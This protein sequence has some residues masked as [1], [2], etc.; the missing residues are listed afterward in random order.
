[1]TWQNMFQ[2]TTTLGEDPRSYWG[3]FFEGKTGLHPLS[4]WT[5]E[6]D[7][8]DGNRT[9]ANY[10][11]SPAG[12][13]ATA[14]LISP[15]VLQLQGTTAGAGN[16]DWFQAPSAIEIADVRTKRWMF[17]YRLSCAHAPAAASR[18]AAGFFASTG[19]IMVGL[20]YGGAVANWQYSRATNTVANTL[21]TGKAIDSSG[22]VFPWV[23]LF[24]D[25]TN[26]RYCIDVL[27]GGVEATAEV[28]A[29]LPVSPGYMYLMNNGA[30]AS[31]LVKLDTVFGFCER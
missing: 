7:F 20:G 31:D 2:G 10:G 29:N 28:A 12:T 22:N 9:A 19:N 23:Y 1:M 17:A 3:N 13:G 15:T 18:V 5:F 11:T 16:C 21:D 27:G 6:Q 30:G 14:S 8:N 24:N 4:Y 26:V 25:G